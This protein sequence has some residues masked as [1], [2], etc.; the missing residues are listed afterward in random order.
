[1]PTSDETRFVA[2]SRR[3]DLTSWGFPGG[4]VDPGETPLQAAVR[5]CTEELGWTPDA[6][7]LVPLYCGAVYGKT[8]AHHFWVITYLYTGTSPE[9]GQC[10]PEMGLAVRELCAP[11]LCDSATS[12]FWAYNLQVARALHEYRDL[13]KTADAGGS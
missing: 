6:D 12:P 1:M 2:V 9:V 8:D 7:M 10:H 3:N 13:C 11:K 5:E 4:K